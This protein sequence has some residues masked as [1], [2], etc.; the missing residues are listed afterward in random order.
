LT[1]GL[2][3]ET[4]TRKTVVRLAVSAVLMFVA[5]FAIMPPL[6]T[7]LCQITGL[8]KVGGAYEAEEIRVETEREVTVQF[9]ATH[10]D[11]MA[12]E[13][14][15]MEYKVKVSPGQKVV[16]KYFAKNNTDKPMVA[17]AVPSISP[18]SAVNYFH[19][20]ECFCFNHQPL[21]AGES[22][23]LGLE[24]VVD[25]DLPKQVTTI[26]LSYT[27]FDITAQVQAQAQVAQLP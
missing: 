20:I 4:A 5:V 21:A 10:N 9:V 24:F 8:R 25:Q 6:Y 17:Q 16:V 13:F 2:T 3:V 27:L 19:K 14:R 22:A 15:P 11:S 1:E 23:E 18:F 26:T 7:L 12:W